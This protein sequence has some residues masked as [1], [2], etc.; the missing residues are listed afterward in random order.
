MNMTMSNFIQVDKNLLVLYPND[1]ANCTAGLN[2]NNPRFSQSRG[3]HMH[4]LL[5]SN[6]AIMTSLRMKNVKTINAQFSPKKLI[7]NSLDI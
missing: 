4:C 3:V 7:P 6:L 2:K 5:H 1:A